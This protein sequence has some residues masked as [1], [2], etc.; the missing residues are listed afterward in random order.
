MTASI[1]WG[2]IAELLWVGPVAAI[3][4]SLAYSLLILGVARAGDARREGAGGVAALYGTLA[5]VAAVAFF[6]MVVFGITVIAAK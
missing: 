4:V 2:T 6:G 5:I 1:D 3:A